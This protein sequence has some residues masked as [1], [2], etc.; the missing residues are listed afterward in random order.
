MNSSEK[1]VAFAAECKLIAKLTHTPGDK[2]VWRQM[3]ERWLRCAALSLQETSTARYSHL[4]KRHRTPARDG[5][6]EGI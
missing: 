6:H 3:S 1:F 5:A 2:A 4:A